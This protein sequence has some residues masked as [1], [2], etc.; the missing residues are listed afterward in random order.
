MTDQELVDLAEMAARCRGGGVG[1]LQHLGML[2]GTADRILSQVPLLVDELREAR[3]RLAE[4]E[5]P[6][7][8]W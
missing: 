1:N 8:A 5:P 2:L 7:P 6:K 4:L 3:R